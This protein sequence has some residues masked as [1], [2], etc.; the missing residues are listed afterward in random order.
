M[1][2]VTGSK[3]AQSI[4]GRGFS[5]VEIVLVLGLIAIASSIVITNFASFTN[6]NDT[7]S[8]EE[9][10]LEAIRFARIEAAKNQSISALYFDDSI[11]ALIVENNSISAE[12][13]KLGKGFG[14]EFNSE[15]TFYLIKP[16]EGFEPFNEGLDQS[17]ELKRVQFDSD[18]SST[19][20]NAL[21][22]EGTNPPQTI[23]FDPFS[24]FPMMPKNES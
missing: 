22:K 3:T 13:F 15:I 4:S 18:R 8:S 12:T 1:T 17:I 2:L 19:P 6:K 7:I 16:A 24:H 23:S 5:L 20:F 21:I 10:L 11:G 14:A 9:V